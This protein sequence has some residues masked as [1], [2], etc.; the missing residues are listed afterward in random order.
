MKQKIKLLVSVA[1][2]TLITGCFPWPHTTP[3]SAEVRGRVLDAGTHAPIPGAMVFLIQSPTHT[4]HTDVD[5]YF[6]LRATRNFH[7]ASNEGG[8]WPDNKSDIVEISYPN[9]SPYSFAAGM[10]GSNDVGIILLEPR[11]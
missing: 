2:L 6:I 7:L 3:R 9:Y 1:V 4:T 8:G 10:T 11:R 5:G